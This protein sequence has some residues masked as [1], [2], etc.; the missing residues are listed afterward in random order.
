[1]EIVILQ[2]DITTLPV[3]AIVNAAN[4]SLLGG[5]GVDGAIHRAAGPK[6]L[7]ACREIRRTTLPEGLPVSQA[8]C[9]PGFNLPA[10]WVIHTVG[11]NRHAGQTDPYLLESAFHNSLQEAV[12]LGARTIAFPAI[13]GGVYGWDLEEVARIGVE[14][15]DRFESS[16]PEACP[17]C[18][19]TVTFALFS[20]K[21][22]RCFREALDRLN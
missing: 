20:D 12:Q 2:A 17:G 18:L 22:E 4:S 21:A 1:M 15:V 6:L 7:E 13:S 5:G 9:T 16:L 11:P 14:T 10:K 19:E 8:V 3:D